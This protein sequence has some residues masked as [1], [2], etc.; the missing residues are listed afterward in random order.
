M[1]W[2]GHFV[3][4]SFS[5]LALGKFVFFSSQPS[6]LLLTIELKCF[7]FLGSISPRPPS[8]PSGFDEAP[9]GRSSFVGPMPGGM[10]SHKHNVRHDISA[11]KNKMLNIALRACL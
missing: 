11:R 8:S 2:L 5:V 7:S 3:F 6:L 9:S 1:E 10:T 4:F